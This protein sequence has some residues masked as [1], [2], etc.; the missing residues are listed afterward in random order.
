MVRRAHL[1]LQ[2][3]TLYVQRNSVLQPLLTV[4]HRARTAN[5]I[6]IQTPPLLTPQQHPHHLPPFAPQL[7]PPQQQPAPS[8]VAGFMLCA[9]IRVHTYSQAVSIA[10][11][12]KQVCIKGLH[13]RQVH[14]Q[15]EL[16]CLVALGQG[17]SHARVGRA[18]SKGPA[19]TNITTKGIWAGLLS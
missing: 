3:A 11:V 16:S 18:S 10:C 6:T 4:D 9:D 19:T 5:T 14:E 7:I 15:K 13:N 1:A 8:G 2:T 17:L 12:R